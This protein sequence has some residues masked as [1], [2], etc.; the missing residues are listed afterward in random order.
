[1]FTRQVC[2]YKEKKHIAA[3]DWQV[4]YEKLTCFS[5]TS[6]ISY[7]KEEKNEQEFHKV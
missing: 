3:S 2:C 4:H 5:A 7:Y 6:I 1:M